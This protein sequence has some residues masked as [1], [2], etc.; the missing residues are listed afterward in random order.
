MVKILVMDKGKIAKPGRTIKRNKPGAGKFEKKALIH[1]K[2]YTKGKSAETVKEYYPAQVTFDSEQLVHRTTID[3]LYGKGSAN[4][5]LFKNLLNIT[6]LHSK[7][8]AELVFEITPKTFASY[9]VEGKRIPRHMLEK[10]IKLEELYLKGIELFGSA[11]KF[12]DWMKKESYGLGLRVP[13][14]LVSTVT[15]IEMI[16]DELVKI[17]FGTTA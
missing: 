15:G 9:M 6:K 8:L 12:N 11:L 1:E 3:I 17:E 13:L 7:T 10:G 2:R 5:P 4:S 16:Y 14:D